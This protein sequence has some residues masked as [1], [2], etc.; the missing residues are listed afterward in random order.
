MGQRLAI[1]GGAGF[2]GANLGLWWRERFPDSTVF[3]F[4]NLRRR[5]SEW[6]L[7]RL[8]AAG[9]EF[10]HG[11]IRNPEDL[12]RLPT[13]DL[14]IDCAAEPAVT[15]ESGGS[16]RELLNINLSGTLNCLE[17]ARE[18]QARFLFLSTSRIYPIAPLNGIPR[19][20]TETRFHWMPTAAQGLGVTTQGISEDLP[21]TGFRSFYGAAKLASELLI[22]EYCAAYGLQALINRCGI[23]AGP[24]QFGKVDQGVITLWVARH[25]FGTA[26]QYIG[27]GGTGKQVRDVLHIHDLFELLERQL[28]E[29][30]VWDG[31]VYN[32]GGGQQNSVSLCELTTLCQRITGRSIPIA[33]RPETHRLDLGIYITDHSRVSARFGWQP[34]RTVADTVGDIY[35]WLLSDLEQLR[36]LFA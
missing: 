12:A 28:A 8:K 13:V 15:A 32:V 30:E 7:P 11:D 6:N 1:T 22:Q 34:R 35:R 26:L 21:L 31:R 18:R 20:E 2:V 9:V 19:E 14:L 16:P 25:V 27:F 5:G 17:A 29:P 3:A 23:L 10:I 24:G 36:P 4:D 33:A